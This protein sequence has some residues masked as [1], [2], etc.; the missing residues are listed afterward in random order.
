MQVRTSK[1]HWREITRIDSNSQ[2]NASLITAL[3]LKVTQ[4]ETKVAIYAALGS[5]VGGTLVAAVMHFWK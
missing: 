4:L 3:T 1:G 5:F 2:A